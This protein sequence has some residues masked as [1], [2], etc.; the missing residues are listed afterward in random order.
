MA[1]KFRLS[2]NFNFNLSETAIL[3]TH[4]LFIS[5]SWAYDDL[6]QRLTN[7]LANR[8]YYNFKNYSVPRANPIIG[9][10]TDK[11]LESAIE[12]KMK[13]SSAVVILAGVYSTY[14]KWIKKEIAIAKRLGK[15][16]IAVKPWG[17]NK[18]SSVVR[19]AADVECGWNADSIVKAIRKVV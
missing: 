3:N 12:S 16:I 13:V 9:A 8:P 1:N 17:S 5:H 10:N 19:Q 14:S 7:L 11:Q 4:N 18:I 6:Y 15:P 2:D